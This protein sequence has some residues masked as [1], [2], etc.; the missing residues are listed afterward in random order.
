MTK[1]AN[2][3]KTLVEERPISMSPPHGGRHNLGFQSDDPQRT[4]PRPRLEGDQHDPRAVNHDP[5]AVNYDPKAANYDPRVVNHDPRA[6]NYDPKAANYDP[7]AANYDPK[8]ANYDPKAANYTNRDKH[9][10]RTRQP[11]RPPRENGYHSESSRYYSDSAQ[12]EGGRT[13]DDLN[14]PYSLERRSRNVKRV[15]TRGL[16]RVDY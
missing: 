13:N 3:H 2:Y 5:R 14:D 12:R 15:P 4:C 10:R 11:Q 7:K 1:T 16:T 8:A 6:A 9:D